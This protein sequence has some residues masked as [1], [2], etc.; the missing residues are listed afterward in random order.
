MRD[1]KCNLS[2]IHNEEF[3]KEIETVLINFLPDYFYKIPAS[4]SGKY[5]PS[6]TSCEGGLVNHTQFAIDTALEL[7]QIYE[8][9]EIEQDIIISSLLLHDGMK[10]GTQEDYEQNGHSLKNHADIMSEA[11]EKVWLKDNSDSFIETSLIKLYEEK[12]RT[13]NCVRSHMGKWSTTYRPE[14]DL[15]KFVHLCDYI[16][17]RKFIDNYYN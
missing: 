12:L 4:T 2:L 17:S 3:R 6:F 1:L 7:F 11:L 8:F 5:H 16:A 13:I 9:N 10:C 14:T 15:E